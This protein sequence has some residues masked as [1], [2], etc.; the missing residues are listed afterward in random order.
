[1]LKLKINWRQLAKM[2]WDALKPVLLGAVGGGVIALSGGCSSMVPS[3]KTQSMGV[4]AFGIPGIAVI[5]QTTQAADYTGGDTNS[6]M[7]ANSQLR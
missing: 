4:Y 2:V 6:A 3:T 5:T 7:Q 1:M